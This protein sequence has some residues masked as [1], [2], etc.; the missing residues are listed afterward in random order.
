MRK[1]NEKNRINLLLF[2]AVMAF[3]AVAFAQDDPPTDPP[4]NPPANPPTNPTREA[5][6]EVAE[7]TASAT[8]KMDETER[9]DAVETSDK[10]QKDEK[11][12][13]IYHEPPARLA[14]GQ[15]ANLIARVQADWKLDEVVVSLRPVGSTAEFTTYEM[16]RSNSK[17]AW[18]AVI[19]G[20][21]VQPPGVE[22]FIESKGAEASDETRFA[23]A[24]APHPVSVIGETELTRTRSRLARHD[25][26][27]SEFTLDVDYTSFGSRAHR[28]P[29]TGEVF[30]T[31]ALT[32]RYGVAELSYRYRTLSL[33][34]DFSFGLGVMRG[35][36]PTYEDDGTT[37][38]I[39]DG[40]PEPGF[41]YGFG[42]TTFELHRNFSVE[43]RIVLG[44]SQ[45]GFAAGAGG[46]VRV[47]RIA[48][49]RLEVGGE[50]LQDF[51]NLFFLRFAWDTVERIPMS[52]EM[53]LGERPDP[54]TSSN[55][56]RL[57]YKAGYEF[58]GGL[59]LHAKVGYASRS[60]GLDAGFVGGLG[61]SYG[62]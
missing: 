50:V 11:R 41:N 5:A 30:A 15:T 43:P 32:D 22:Y 28:D 1:S 18:V 45:R 6:K 52:L 46:L 10:E 9:D 47:G 2:L 20:Q 44:A 36:R 16:E 61:V 8:E 14:A 58:D 53:E 38:S 12:P 37:L 35:Q 59:T 31:E 42:Q 55:G 60:T 48:G 21:I 24:D 56:V 33:L 13:W 29:E 27:R 54:E 40:R 51:G 34:Y 19:P 25:G 3:P 57:V 23:T 39:A 7:A 4:A 62:F 49:T 17:D 26:E